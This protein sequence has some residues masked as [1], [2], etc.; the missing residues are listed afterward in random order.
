MDFLIVF[1]LLI[2]FVVLGTNL[3]LSGGG[4]FAPKP[5]GTN[6]FGTATNPQQPGLFGNAGGLQ[7]GGG[8]AGN[9]GTGTFNTGIKIY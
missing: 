4:L 1:L 7:M 3:N 6:I 9:L 8:L 2:N 5:A